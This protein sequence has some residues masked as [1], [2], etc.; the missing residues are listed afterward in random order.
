MGNKNTL[1]TKEDINECHIFDELKDWWKRL[2][3]NAK[4]NKNTNLTFQQTGYILWRIHQHKYDK[5]WAREL[6]DMPS[7]E[8]V[9]L[10][11]NENTNEYMELLGRIFVYDLN[12]PKID[13]VSFDHLI[14]KYNKLRRKDKS[15]D[16]SMV[17]ETIKKNEQGNVTKENLKKWLHYVY[18]T[19]KLNGEA[20][21]NKVEEIINDIFEK[22]NPSEKDTLSLSEFQNLNNNNDS[23][24][25]DNFNFRE[26]LTR[27]A[28][29]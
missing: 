2:Y 4:N 18:H 14:L 3:P 27:L 17:F 28:D 19:D 23:L 12:D 6:P 21:D 9:K 20:L 29:M 26:I 15:I 11:L 1:L 7:V 10:S 24:W 5:G 8:K 13:G 16:Q 25:N 22:A